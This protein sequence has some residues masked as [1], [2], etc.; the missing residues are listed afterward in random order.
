MDDAANDGRTW[1]R[2]PNGMDT[3][4]VSDWKFQLG[5]K[6]GQN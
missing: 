6:G 2:V 4:A 3:G 1:Q 5:T